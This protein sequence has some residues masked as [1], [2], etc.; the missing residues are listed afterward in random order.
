MDAPTSVGG[1]SS[2]ALREQIH[3]TQLQLGAKLGALEGEVRAVTSHAKDAIRERFENA[4]DIVDI[5]RHVARRP[6]LWSALAVGVGVM[7]GR[8]GGRSQSAGAEPSRPGALRRVVAPHIA[9]LQTFLVG[10]A[11]SFAAER[12]KERATGLR[13]GSDPS[14]APD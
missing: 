4:R 7:A 12:L 6:W 5:R 3:Q 10:Q 2:S 11:L 13:N 14:S 1:D 8:R 9:T